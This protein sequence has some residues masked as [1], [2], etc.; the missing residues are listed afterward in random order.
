MNLGFRKK[1]QS[2]TWITF[3]G[4]LFWA[5]SILGRSMGDQAVY[6]NA[7]T[8][9]SFAFESALCILLIMVAATILSRF[10]SKPGA[11]KGLALT[12]VGAKVGYLLCVGIGQSSGIDLSEPITALV[13]IGN[14][15]IVLF[16]GLNFAV[17]D[18]V[19]A[20]R[21]ALFTLL[22]GFA[23]FLA[24]T[25]VPLGSGYIYLSGILNIVAILPFLLGLYTISVNA[26]RKAMPGCTP[27]L[28]R[29]LAMRMVFGISI[30]LSTY[31]ATNIAPV[32]PGCLPLGSIAVLLA[33]ILF[34]LHMKRT[35]R[36]DTTAL[37]IAPFLACGV[38]IVPFL[39]TG[40]EGRGVEKLMPLLCWLCW[41][42]LSSV[43]VSD[44]KSRIGWDEARLSFSEKA[45]MQLALLTTMIVLELPIGIEKVIGGQGE[46]PFF[47]LLGIT[48]LT[49]L[50][51]SYTLSN[52]IDAKTHQRL[53]DKALEITE[54][55]R[56]CIY[57]EIV[58]AHQLTEREDEV[59][60]L[61]AKGH[62][63][64]YI[65]DALTISEGTARSHATHINQK[66]GIHS[67]EELLE[68]VKTYET[69]YLDRT[70]R[71]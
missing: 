46:T 54:S 6:L 9:I 52:I 3:G 19:H 47:V 29:F 50:I 13:G 55:Q 33:I 11:Q 69:E 41:T 51:S 24:S 20:E 25:L 68:L 26:P 22:G 63:R 60:C 38:L 10:F 65:C 71:P 30:G 32:L 28:V 40:H 5:A 39:G 49:M 58:K 14:A 1:P 18:K 21:T 31:A 15:C 53:M 48:Y 45:A 34:A 61:M 16:W 35:K 42:V 56:R 43:Q 2:H 66:L 57:D 23:I 62:T 4:S 37:R 17:L 67:R 70:G 27:L 44:V 7:K 36:I 12:A 8:S 59:F 64:P